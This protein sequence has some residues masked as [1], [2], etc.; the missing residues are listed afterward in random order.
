MEEAA[1]LPQGQLLGVTQCGLYNVVYTMWS[2]SL[3]CT[4]G[5][6]RYWSE[7]LEDE[8]AGLCNRF[9]WNPILCTTDY[10]LVYFSMTEEEWIHLE[11]VSSV[12]PTVK[13]CLHWDITRMARNYRADVVLFFHATISRRVYIIKGNGIF[14]YLRCILCEIGQMLTILQCSTKFL[15]CF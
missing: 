2:W 10:E 9:I 3:I 11:C 15:I 4:V 5:T 14:I 7:S 8:R 13:N 6:I 12:I 1:V